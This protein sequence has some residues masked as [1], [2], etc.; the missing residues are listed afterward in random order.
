M[1]IEATQDEFTQ[2]GDRQKAEEHQ[3][4]NGGQS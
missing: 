1:W 2:E 4:L 3:Y